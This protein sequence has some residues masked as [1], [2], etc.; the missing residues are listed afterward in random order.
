MSKKKFLK[1]IAMDSGI[2]ELVGEMWSTRDTFCL[3]WVEL[4]ISGLWESHTGKDGKCVLRWETRKLAEEAVEA[5]AMNELIRM[6]NCLSCV[7][8][9]EI[10][11]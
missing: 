11:E 5:A 10:E 6:L 9:V 7:E 1:W 3:G 8:S 4:T 2:H